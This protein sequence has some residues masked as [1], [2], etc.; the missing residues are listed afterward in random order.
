MPR[1][2]R[3]ACRIYVVYSASSRMNDD[4]M[5]RQK[6]ESTR[7]QGSDDCSSCHLP[8]VSIR[9]GADDAR[10]SYGCGAKC[11]EQVF[12]NVLRMLWCRDHFLA[13]ASL[14]HCAL[15]AKHTSHTIASKPRSSIITVHQKTSQSDVTVDLDRWNASRDW[16]P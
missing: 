16:M 13:P 9:A 10:R 15:P 14:A 7:E 11:P 12:G 8:I 3:K 2:R 4:R 5:G 6:A 1:E